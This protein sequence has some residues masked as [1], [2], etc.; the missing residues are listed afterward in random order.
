[1]Y[2]YPVWIAPL[3][4]KFTPLAEGALRDTIFAVAEKVG[5]KTSGIFVMDGSKRSSHGNAY[6]TGFGKNK[7]IVLF[8]TLIENLGDAGTVAVLAHEM[9]HQ[10]K[11][12]IKKLL[13]L[14]LLIMLVGFWILS[15]LINYLP[16]FEAF[17]F[18]QTSYH[19]A[20]IIFSFAAAPVTYF[21]S[22]LISVLSRRFEYQADRFAVAATGNGTDLTEALLALSKKN[23]SNLTPHPWFSFFHYSHPTLHERLRAIQKQSLAF[24]SELL[25]FQALRV[26]YLLL[27]A[28]VTKIESAANMEI[29][30]E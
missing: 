17:G 10:K 29:S 26:R 12:H 13:C 30:H 3:F 27:E 8:D 5:F 14:S 6:F 11:N 2:V 25:S 18:K 21:L 9:G 19:G 20:L 28:F 23:L 7:R 4:N 16:F 15:L 24:I 1:M 22:P